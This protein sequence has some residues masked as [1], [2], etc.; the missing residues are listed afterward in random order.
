[1]AFID[2]IVELARLLQILRNTSG[3]VEVGYLGIYNCNH[4]I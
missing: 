2:T 1:M 4:Y 3:L